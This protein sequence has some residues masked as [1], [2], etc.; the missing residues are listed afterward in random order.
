MPDVFVADGVKEPASGGGEREPIIRHETVLDREKPTVNPLA[1]FVIRP[2]TMRFET[3]QQEEHIL[4]L[5]RQHPIVNV[6][7]MVIT[8]LWAGFP[9]ILPLVPGWSFLPPNFQAVGLLVWYLLA[10]GYVLENFLNWYFNVFIVTDERIIDIDF[11]SLLYKKLSSAK[12]VQMEDVTFTQTGIL[13]AILDIGAIS[14]QTAG[15]RREFEIANI[16]QP[17]KVVLFLNEMVGQE[18]EEAIEGRVR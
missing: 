18:E 13:G 6:P 7:W 3:Q 11:Y 17:R 12:L 1:S 15:E 8:I 2:R 10:F 5:L 4:L 9:T 14:I 16:P